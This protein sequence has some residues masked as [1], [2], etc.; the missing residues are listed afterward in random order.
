MATR[1]LCSIA[2]DACQLRPVIRCID[3]AE[4]P[5]LVW[6]IRQATISQ[7]ANGI[8]VRASSVPVVTPNQ[9]RQSAHQCRSPAARRRTTP[10]RGQASPSGQRSSV[11]YDRA[12]A[13][14][15]NHS[16][17]WRSPPGKCSPDRA[18]PSMVAHAPR[19]IVSHYRRL[20]THP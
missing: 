12:S 4:I 18:A 9:R 19:R 15:A 16:K 11:R 5:F 14:V 1:I 3:R 17:N 7:V 13:S 6:V 20:P 10:Q 8:L 2:H